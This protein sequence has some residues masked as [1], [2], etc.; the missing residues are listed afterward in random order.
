VP[1][2]GLQIS[3]QQ[4]FL[5]GDHL[6]GNITSQ[7]SRSPNASSNPALQVIE[8]S[9]FGSISRNSRDIES[10][11]AEQPSSTPKPST[12]VE[13]WQT[14]ASTTNQSE[15]AALA[16]SS[17]KPVRETGSP[18]IT[19][20]IDSQSGEKSSATP[21]PAKMPLATQSTS[22]ITEEEPKEWLSRKVQSFK[23]EIQTLNRDTATRIMKITS[24]EQEIEDFKNEDDKYRQNKEKEIARVLREID[25]RYNREHDALKVKME[26]HNKAKQS[27]L[28]GL[29]RNSLEVARKETGLKRFQAIIEYYEADGDGY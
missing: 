10:P 13:H 26:A 16:T 17:P 2:N 18:Q 24:I 15:T 19:S 7:M 14:I 27:E 3:Q 25:E 1:S 21:Q 8:G 22:T 29:N 28:D 5:T 4:A 6:L 9:R 20:K 11:L 23:A 12:P